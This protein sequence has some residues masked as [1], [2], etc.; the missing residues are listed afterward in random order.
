[1]AFGRLLLWGS[2][3]IRPKQKPDGFDD[4]ASILSHETPAQILERFHVINGIGVKRPQACSL[5]DDILLVKAFDP[6]SLVG[7]LENA[8]EYDTVQRKITH[9]PLVTS[10]YVG[11]NAATYH[12]VGLIYETQRDDVRIARCFPSDIGSTPTTL[13]TA[14]RLSDHNKK[15]ELMDWEGVRICSDVRIASLLN[16]AYW[17]TEIWLDA[18]KPIS[19]R[20]VFVREHNSYVD[21]S[22]CRGTK[23]DVCRGLAAR[24]LARNTGLPIVVLP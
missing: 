22:W 7:A 19:A 3:N 8:I 24:I 5:P 21:A 1:M 18:D 15:T 10:S 6:E 23:G 16:S 9:L 20:A 12:G 17:H 14:P 13:R 2:Q 4:L 11:P